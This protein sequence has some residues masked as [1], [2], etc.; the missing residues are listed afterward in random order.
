MKS[1]QNDNEELLKKGKKYHLTRARDIH[2]TYV[3]AMHLKL[4]PIISRFRVRIGQDTS[5]TGLTI[6]FRFPRFT[7]CHIPL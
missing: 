4:I 2:L 6:S 7:T 5:T 3:H 1:V